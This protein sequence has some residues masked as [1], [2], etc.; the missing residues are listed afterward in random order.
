[1]EKDLK[2][3]PI[4]DYSGFERLLEQGNANKIIAETKMNATSRYD[5]ILFKSFNN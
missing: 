1:L 2:P 5:V 4:C 3:T